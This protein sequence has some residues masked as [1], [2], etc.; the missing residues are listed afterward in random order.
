MV[1]FLTRIIEITN[2]EVLWLAEIHVFDN[3]IL[4]LLWIIKHLWIHPLLRSPLNKLA[5]THRLNWLWHELIVL[6]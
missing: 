4:H 3:M 1:N 2:V 6:W 5:Q